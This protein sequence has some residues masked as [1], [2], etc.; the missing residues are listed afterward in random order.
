[1]KLLYTEHSLWEFDFIKNDIFHTIP[2]EVEMIN[3]TNLNTLL[4]RTDIIENC[5]IVANDIFNFNDL[6][7]VVKYIK[8]IAIFYF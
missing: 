8:P 4:D 7:T 1:M 6:L 5:V 2:I 3:R